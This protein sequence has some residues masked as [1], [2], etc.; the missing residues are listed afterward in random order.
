MQALYWAKN[1]GYVAPYIPAPA[2]YL[3]DETQKIAEEAATQFESGWE[4]MLGQ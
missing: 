4:R 1:I 3:G 2:K